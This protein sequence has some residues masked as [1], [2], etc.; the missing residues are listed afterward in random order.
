MAKLY[1]YYGAMTAG[2]SL[3]LLKVAHNYEEQGKRV[4]V[5]TSGIDDRYGIGKVSSRVGISRKA[6]PINQDDNVT[7]L[8][9]EEL[10]KDDKDISCVLIDEAQFLSKKNI[11]GLVTIKE[12]YDTAVIAYG[13]KTDF[14]NNLFEGSEQLLIHAENISEIKT[15]CTKQECEKKAIMNIRM[16]AEGQAL[17]H[18]EQVVIGDESY[19]PVCSYHYYNFN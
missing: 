7:D 8:F 14:S 6:I 13:L 16:N 11:M 19:V 18:G 10:T 5:L 4:L 15:I 9:L 3:E 1:F 17:Y 2:K 12:H